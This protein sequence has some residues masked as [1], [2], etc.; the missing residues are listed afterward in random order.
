M[1]WVVYQTTCPSFCAAAISAGSA[2]R[3]GPARPASRIASRMARRCPV[4]CRMSRAP[5]SLPRCFS[6]LALGRLSANT[7]GKSGRKERA[8]VQEENRSQ[9]RGGG[10][11]RSAIAVWLAAVGAASPAFADPIEDFY[12]GKQLT[13][14]IRGTPGGNYDSYSRLLARYLPKYIPGNPVAV[15]VNMPAG[16]GLVAFNQ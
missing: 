7:P 14:V 15:P 5:S 13:I 3:A 16:G 9:K 1:I 10:A 4:Y 11:R 12:R 2:A 8:G 6:F